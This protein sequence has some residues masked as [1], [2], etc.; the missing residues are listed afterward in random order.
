MAFNKATGMWEEEDASVAK[1]INELTSVDSPMMEGAKTAGLE[2]AARRGLGNSTMAVE[3]SQKAVIDRAQPIASQDA[4]QIHQRNMSRQGFGQDDVL[5]GKRIVSQEKIAA[6]E[7]ATRTAIAQMQENA[8][9]ERLKAQGVQQKELQFMQDSAAKER[10]GI[11]L[12]SEEKRAAD[13]LNASMERLKLSEEEARKRLDV[14]EGNQN[15]RFL[16]S[17]A[18]QNT[19]AKAAEDA[20]LARL[21]ISESGADRRATSQ[22]MG[23]QQRAILSYFSAQSS[24]YSSAISNLMNNTNIPAETRTQ[25]IQH[26]NT[27]RD[28][29]LNMVQQMFGVN[30]TWARPGA[31]A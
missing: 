10:L 29:D 27:L 16:I 5:Q 15:Q 7:R 25:M 28:S 14:T 20:A 4:G 9:M 17:E 2:T 31:T 3:A 24:Q 8:A 30:L 12:T 19:R 1:K 22:N 13:E 6:E 23:E 26:Y 21:G 11:S 18:N